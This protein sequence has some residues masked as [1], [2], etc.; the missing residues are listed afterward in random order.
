MIFL[1]ILSVFS[2]SLDSISLNY[3][4]KGLEV[5]GVEEKE[6][7]YEKRWAT[8]TLYRLFI[9]DQIFEKP[10]LTPKYLDENVL[11]LN[12]NKDSLVKTY[13]FLLN[14]LKRKDFQEFSEKKEI[15]KIKKEIEDKGKSLKNL[16]GEN[17]NLYYLI[18][19]F[20]VG[21]NYYKKA[22]SKLKEEEIYTLLAEI[23]YLFSDEEASDDDYLRGA[24]LRENN[25]FYDTTKEIELESLF[26]LL[27][28]VE[29][30]DLYRAN[31]AYL[32][33][34]ESFL[35]E[36]RNLSLEKDLE[37]L[38][39]EGISI[40]LGGKKN[41][42]YNKEYRIIIDLDGNDCYLVKNQGI[43]LEKFSSLIVDLAG[44]DYY[45]NESNI[46]TFASG[47][48]GSGFLFDFKGNDV[49]YSGNFSLASGVLGVGILWDLE[50]NDIYQ[51]KTFS[52]ASG[53]YGLGMLF[54][55]SGNDNYRIY[56]FG[57][58]FGSTFGYGILFDLEGNDIYYAGGKYFHIPLLPKDYRSFAQGFAI[59]F[60]PEAS[61]GIG[62]LCDM[63]GNDFYNSDVFGQGC[64]YWYSL[65]MLYDGEG[66]D[67][68]YATEYAQGAGIHL[69]AGIL[70]DNDGDDF[71]YSRLGPSQGEGHDLAVGILID[72]DGDDFYYASGGQGI[73]LTNSFGLFLD[74][75][76]N[77]LYFNRE[78]KFGQG[79]A[80]QAR[81]FGGIGLF[82]DL[83]GKDIYGKKGMGEDGSIWT[84]GIYAY[85]IDDLKEKE[86]KIEKEDILEK[87]LEKMEIEELF[88]YASKWEVG[89]AKRIVREARRELIKRKEAA[90]EYI[91]KKKL[92]TKNSLELRAIEE[93][94]C[95]LPS[96]I[97]PHLMDSIDNNNIQVRANVIYLLGKIKAKEA[98]PLLAKALKDKRNR[99]R[100][101][102][103]AFAE[104]GDTSA[105]S[106]IINYLNSAD[107]PTR[108]FACYAL[109]KLKDR[110]GTKY[111]IAKLKDPL[112]TVRQS[113]EI[114]LAEI[115]S[116][117]LPELF[118]NLLK[119][120]NENFKANILRTIN[121]I[122]P[123]LDTLKN[124]KER[125]EVK[126]ILI[127]Y[128]DTENLSLKSLAIEGLSLFKEKEIKEILKSKIPFESSPLILRK[129]KE[130]T[131][132]L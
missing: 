34:I 31:L 17:K 85:G 130:A 75:N 95:S 41:N 76:G 25:I 11:F 87:D 1:F 131:E 120:K 123:Q 21:D 80:N 51:G 28:K 96:L 81:G 66:N 19:S 129:L 46:F 119:S 79:F 42:S 15:G 72:N 45:R 35:K 6:L 70:V 74:K 38:E 22:F 114:A 68:Y 20:L 132:G 100:W 24:I 83:K 115:G 94:A 58:A 64:S 63:K 48:L 2:Q 106:E 50:G 55:F 103:N 67:K 43:V 26:A 104:I 122:I 126:N 7:G 54:D 65:G 84:G 97:K 118:D 13:L 93:V 108:I 86:E 3:I 82:I 57:Q 9:I 33:G 71:Y 116:S 27:R 91:V 112:F 73:G 124:L 4:K 121:R 5:L 60:R 61:G 10:L 16:K 29:M 40:A 8:D 12:S 18:S 77:D 127:S 14:Q 117:I 98:L 39:I 47:I 78:E 52:C 107:E 105:F 128:L 99:P 30:I 56:N 59:G 44:D 111:L 53:F 36:V 88:K 102:L 37:E 109:G 69:A 125:V 62:L 113:A 23:P 92:S 89:S 101:I 110:R 90:I 49:Y 32:I